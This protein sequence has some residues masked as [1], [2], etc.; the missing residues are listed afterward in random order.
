MDSTLTALNSAASGVQTNLRKLN[1]TAQEVAS[2]GAGGG[3]PTDLAAALVDAIVAQHAL[4]ASASVMRRAD[5][6]LG[7]IIDTSA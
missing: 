4:E 1:Q 3:E 2:A 7:S 5:E 6:V